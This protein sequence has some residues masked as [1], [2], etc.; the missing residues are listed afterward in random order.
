MFLMPHFPVQPRDKVKHITSSFIHQTEECQA[1]YET[2]SCFD[3]KLSCSSDFRSVSQK[4]SLVSACCG[5]E[6][7][8]QNEV[9]FP[10]TNAAFRFLLPK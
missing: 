7:S 2:I 4:T 3:L 9:W 1:E 5:F 10:C 6:V 8:Y